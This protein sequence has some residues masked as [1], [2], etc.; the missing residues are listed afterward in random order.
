MK[1]V[2][3][4]IL[5]VIVVAGAWWNFSPRSSFT[6]PE[7]ASEVTTTPAPMKSPEEI[8]AADYEKIAKHL[9]AKNTS[10]DEWK[11]INNYSLTPEALVTNAN[12]KTYFKTAQSNVPD[13][14]SCLKK[15][16]C[17]M[18]TRG[19]H[20]AYF[21]DQKTPAHILL[22]RNLK[23]MKESLRKDGSLKSEVD[24]DLMK[25]LATSGSDMLSVEALDIIR[26]FDSESV[27][28]DELIKVTQNLKGQAR[29]DA[30]VRL[31]RKSNSTDKILLAS[32]VE[33][34][35][36]NPNSDANTVISVLENLRNMSLGANASH[37][38]FHLC[39]FKVADDPQDPNW[40]MIKMLANKV[41]NEFEK[42]CN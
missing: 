15:D 13:I 27:K 19:E 17:G 8:V 23:I 38:L 35:F 36:A 16:F 9:S 7:V 39:R 41:N 26:E 25:E 12:A 31:S 20:D 6:A 5:F 30:L 18:E 24:W 29:A 1:K 32:E 4:P 33:D 28:T 21:D 40:L 10:G 2:L 3:L 14:F 22:N 11:Q 42:M 37:A 34:I